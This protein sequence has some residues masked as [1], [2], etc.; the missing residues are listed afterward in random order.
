MA[1]KMKDAASWAGLIVTAVVAIWLGVLPFLVEERKETLRQYL[2][3]IFA[4]TIVA[5]IFF[6]IEKYQNSKDEGQR[7]KDE[8]QRKKDEA[9][10]KIADAKRDAMLNEILKIART[11]GTLSP[12]KATELEQA[13]ALYSTLEKTAN[14]PPEQVASLIREGVKEAV[15]KGKQIYFW[16]ALTELSTKEFTGTEKDRESLRFAADSLVRSALDVPENTEQKKPS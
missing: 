2:W 9:A 3:I 12:Q 5:A 13:Q 8:V 16:K 15:D 7:K 14:K 11:Q 4:L 1:L 6:G 10:R